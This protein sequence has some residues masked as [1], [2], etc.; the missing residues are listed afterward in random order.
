[1]IPIYSHVPPTPGPDPES[2]FGLPDGL[3]YAPHGLRATLWC[4]CLTPTTPALPLFSPK[5]PSIR[6][7]TQLPKAHAMYHLSTTVRLFGPLQGSS[8]ESLERRHVD[9]K[10]AFTRTNNHK[11]CEVQVLRGEM[12]MDDSSDGCKR[13]H[14]G[15]DG[16]A[17]AAKRPRL[18]ARLQTHCTEACDSM[19]CGTQLSTG[20]I[21][22]GTSCSKR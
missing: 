16:Q 22:R 7:E 10:E 1:V 19:L 9:M 11:E 13:Q 8:G 5:K 12:R 18:N 17:G 14:G 20:A 6:P 2:Q 4:P 21:V 15:E 3:T